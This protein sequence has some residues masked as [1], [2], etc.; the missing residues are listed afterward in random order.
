MVVSTPGVKPALRMAGRTAAPLA[1]LF[2]LLERHIVPGK[3]EH[4]VYQ[5]RGVAG[6]QDKPVAIGP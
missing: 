5:H 3:V 4:A 2:D 1:E 6:G